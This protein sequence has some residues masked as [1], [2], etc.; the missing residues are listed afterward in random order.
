MTDPNNAL[1]TFCLGYKDWYANHLA[2]CLRSLRSQTN[3]P[4][5]IADLSVDESSKAAVQQLARAHSAEVVLSPR[6]VWSRSIALNL[7][8]SVAKTQHLVFTDA[9][10]I[11]S[12][13]W[14]RVAERCFEDV[15]ARG[16]KLFKLTRSRD[17][18]GGLAQEYSQF[19]E[20]DEPENREEWLRGV[21]TPHPDIGQG[22]ATVV[23]AE[24]FRRVGGFDEVYSVWGCEDNDLV[25]RAQWDGYTVDWFSSVYVYHQYHSH[26]VGH[27]LIP[28]HEAA[29]V[30]MEHVKFN[31]KYLAQR[32]EEKGPIV[33]NSKA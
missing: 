31:R 3:A 8:A 18:A 30:V 1:F 13:H 22:A 10:M 15:S 33:R 20:Y 27:P 29:Q 19:W 26:G 4:I 32:M 23:T 12:A 11:F 21:S 6:E 2:R 17:L 7:A 16:L 24:W 28:T 9:D 25:L 14:V 5:V